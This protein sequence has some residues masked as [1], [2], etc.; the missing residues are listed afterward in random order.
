MPST[1][2]ESVKDHDQDGIDEQAY[3]RG[4]TFRAKVRR[5]WIPPG[6]SFSEITPKVGSGKTEGIENHFGP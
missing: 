1:P 5:T 3:F 6:N 2:Y 4:I